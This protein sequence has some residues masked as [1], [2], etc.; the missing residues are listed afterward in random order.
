MTNDS[1]TL[2]VVTADHSHAFSFAGYAD[3]GS[4]LSA[5][6]GT[7]DDNMTYTTLN[8]ANGP[9]W[10]NFTAEKRHNISS[11]GETI[12]SLT[13]QQTPL[14][15]LDSETHGGEDVMIF[16]KGPFAHLLTGVQFQSYIPHVMAYASCVGDGLTYCGDSSSAASNLANI[17]IVSVTLSMLK[18]IGYEI[19]A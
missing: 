15:P 11:D 3:R 19:V 1:E 12:H 14:V 9:G 8:Y 17:L 2:I 16:A 7:G 10:K 4:R 6:A 18:L 5:E 13:Y